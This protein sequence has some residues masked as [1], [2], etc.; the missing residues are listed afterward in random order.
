MAIS[1]GVFND[2]TPTSYKATIDET[3]VIITGLKEGIAD[4]LPTE[5]DGTVI[6]LS[7]AVLPEANNSASISITGGDYTLALDSG[8]TKYGATPGAA[9][10]SYENETDWAKATVSRTMSAGWDEGDGS[11]ITYKDDPQELASITGLKKDATSGI[12]LEANS[13]IEVGAA[14][15]GTNTVTLTNKVTSVFNYTLKLADGIADSKSAADN[16]YEVVI[17]SGTLTA[18]AQHNEYWTC[19]GT[20]ITHA[21][22]GKDSSAAATVSN[23][24]NDATATSDAPNVL[25]DAGTNTFTLKKSALQTDANTTVTLTDPNNKGFSLALY[26]GDDTEKVDIAGTQAGTNFSWGIKG[27]KAN[28]TTEAT[29]DEETATKAATI[30]KVLTAGWTLGKSNEGDTTN[31]KITYSAGRTLTYATISGLAPATTKDTLPDLSSV[32]DEEATNENTAKALTLTKANFPT[33]TTTADITLTNEYTTTEDKVK[34]NFKI[35]IAAGTIDTTAVDLDKYEVKIDDSGDTATM[36]VNQMVAEYCDSTDIANGTKL[37]YH[38]EQANATPL[39]TVTGLAKTATFAL[40]TDTAAN[41]EAAAIIVNTASAKEITLK[42]AAFPTSVVAENTVNLTSTDGY[43]LKLSGVTAPGTDSDVVV[44]ED[45]QGT[46][47]KVQQTKT[48]G[49]QLGEAITSEGTKT[50]AVTYLEPEATDLATITVDNSAMG[51]TKDAFTVSGTTVKVANAALYSSNEGNAT[52]ISIDNTEGQT[53]ALALA[54]DVINTFGK[55]NINNPYIGVYDD[56]PEGSRGNKIAEVRQNVSD[57]WQ[58]ATADDVAATE[59]TNIGEIFYK[60]DGY[61][62]LATVTGLTDAADDNTVVLNGTTITLSKDALPDEDAGFDVTSLENNPGQ[63]Y[64]LA[65][66]ETTFNTEDGVTDELKPGTKYDPDTLAIVASDSEQGDGDGGEGG[67]NGN[68]DG[69]TETTVTPV[70]KQITGTLNAGWKL[71]SDSSQVKYFK[72]QENIVLATIKNVG[73][74]LDEN[75][76]GDEEGTEEGTT[77]DTNVLYLT[78]IYLADKSVTL[79]NKTVET[80]DGDTIVGT[81]KGD[82]KLALKDEDNEVKPELGYKENYAWTLNSN[83]T[84]AYFKQGNEKGWSIASDS[85]SVT[86]DPRVNPIADSKAKTLLTVTGLKG[87]DLDTNNN[88]LNT[89]NPDNFLD[90]TASAIGSTIG[91]NFVAGLQIDT[92]YTPAVTADEDN[93]IDAVDAVNG[94]ILLKRNVLGT[95]TLEL[96]GTDKDKYDLKLFGIKKTGAGNEATLEFDDDGNAN[97]FVPSEPFNKY[98]WYVNGTNAFYRKATAEYWALNGKKVTYNQQT[99]GTTLAKITGLASGLKV[100]D[101]DDFTAISTATDLDDNFA[102]KGGFVYSGTTTTDAATALSTKVIEIADEADYVAADTEN[103]SE[104]RI[105]TITISQGALT[106]TNVALTDGKDNYDLKLDDDFNELKTDNYKWEVTGSSTKT[107]KYYGVYATAGYNVTDKADPENKF[108]KSITY[109]AVGDKLLATIT[110]LNKDVTKTNIDNDIYLGEK[111]ITTGEGDDE[112]AVTYP[113]FVLNSNVLGTSDVSLTNNAKTADF[114]LALSSSDE[115]IIDSTTKA[116]EEAIESTEHDVW[117]LSGTTAYFRNITPTYYTPQADAMSIKATAEKKNGND[118]VTVTNLASDLVEQDGE[119]GTMVSGTFTKVIDV[120]KTKEDDLKIVVSKGALNESKALTLTDGQKK[121]TFEFATD[122]NDAPDA[123]E[124]SKEIGKAPKWTVANNTATLKGTF[125]AGWIIDASTT[126]KSKRMVHYNELTGKT[127]ATIKGLPSN[128]SDS[129]FVN[130]ALPTASDG[131][132]VLPAKVF[133]GNINDVT[134]TNGKGSDNNDFKY[135]IAIDTTGVSTAGAAIEGDDRWYLEGTTLSLSKI[136]D[137]HHEDVAVKTDKGTSTDGVSKTTIKYV[138]EVVDTPDVTI[139]NLK[140]DLSLNNSAVTNIVEGDKHTYYKA[141]GNEPITG[142]TVNGKTITLTSAVVS[143]DPANVTTLANKEGAIS[144]QEYKLA[145]DVATITAPGDG[146]SFGIEGTKATLYSGKTAGYEWTSKTIAYKLPT[147]DDPIATITGLKSGLVV[148]GATGTAMD[149]IGTRDADGDFTALVTYPGSGNN[150][151]FTIKQDALTNTDVTVDNGTLVLD[152]EVTAAWTTNKTAYAWKVSGTE[153]TYNRGNKEGWEI[154]TADNSKKITYHKEDYPTVVATV[155]NLASGLQVA[156][157]G[158][159]V[160][161]K[162]KKTAISLGSEGSKDKITL[163]KFALNAKDVLLKIATKDDGSGNVDDSKKFSL[164]LDNTMADAST[165]ADTYVEGKVVTSVWTQDATDKG[166]YIYTVT[167][168]QGYDTITDP[169]ETDLTVNKVVY[170]DRIVYTKDSKNITTL[171]GLATNLSISSDKKTLGSSGQVTVDDTNLKVSVKKAALGGNNV[172]LK[173][174]SIK[175]TLDISDGADPVENVWTISKGTAS[176]IKPYKEKSYLKKSDTE[177]T[178][179]GDTAGK[180]VVLATITG[181]DTNISE[182]KI[183]QTKATTDYG[184]SVTDGADVTT[185]T[186]DDRSKLAAKNIVLKASKDAGDTKYV[187][188]INAANFNTVTYTEDAPLWAFSKGTLTLSTGTS[189]KWDYKSATDH[190]TLTYTKGSTTPAATVKGLATDLTLT[191]NKDGTVDANK[192]LMTAVVKNDSGTVTKNATLALSVDSSGDTNLIKLKEGALVASPKNNAKITLT[193]PKNSTAF[194]LDV[195]GVTK[196]TAAEMDKTNEAVLA[197]QEENKWSISKGTATYQYK[198]SAGWQLDADAKNFTYVNTAKITPLAKISGL[199]TDLTTFNGEKDAKG[200][201]TDVPITQAVFQNDTGIYLEPGTTDEGESITKFTLKDGTKL[202]GKNVTLAVTDKTTNYGI[203]AAADLAP[204]DFDEKV[205]V[206]GTKGTVTLTA[207]TSDGYTNATGKNEGKS[208]TYSKEKTANILFSVTGLKKDTTSTAESAKLATLI[209]VK[210]DGS[211]NESKSALTYNSEEK[212]VSIT[213]T[214]ILD[215]TAS[216]SGKGG[217]TF[218]AFDSS[219]KGVADVNNT[220]TLQIKS[221]TINVVET[222]DKDRYSVSADGKKITFNTKDVYTILATVKGLDKNVMTDAATGTKILTSTTVNKVQTPGA[223]VGTFDAINGTITL[224]DKALA[225]GNIT[226]TLGKNVEEGK[227]SVALGSDVMTE[228]GQWE[229]ITEWTSSNGTATYKTYNKGYY[230]DDGKGGFKYNKETKGT[231]YATITGLNKDADD[232][233]A[234]A[235]NSNTTADYVGEILITKDM[236][237]EKN[238]VLK[239]T[240]DKD[241]NEGAFTIALDTTSGNKVADADISNF[242]AEKTFVSGKLT[243]TQSKGYLKASDTQI[244]YLKDAKSNQLVATLSGIDT[245]A[246]G[247][248]VDNNGV[249]ELGTGTKGLNGKNVTLTTTDLA[250]VDYK[251]RLASGTAESK[252]TA[253][254]DAWTVKNGTA[255]YKGFITEGYALAASGKSITYTKANGSAETTVNGKTKA[256]V[257]KDL[258]T[259]KGVTESNKPTENAAVSGTALSSTNAVEIKDATVTISTGLFP[260]NFKGTSITGSKEADTITIASGKA[261]TV[262]PG[263]GDDKIT[264][265]SGNYKDTFVYSN[266]DG[267]DVVANFTADDTIKLKSGKLTSVEISGSDAVV[268]V[269]TGS[270][271]LT[272]KSTTAINIVDNKGTSLWSAAPTGAS[273]VLLADNNYSQDAAALSDIVEPFHASYTPYDFESGLDLVKKDSFAPAFTYTGDSDKK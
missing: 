109:T 81:A 50:Q 92:K 237:A 163:T 209:V 152:S 194:A 205:T 151:A 12:T 270:I 253:A 30:Q 39:A 106:T 61:N 26:S 252:V 86:F 74:D 192:G 265:D 195:D 47:Y 257:Y 217:Y 133:I 162:N 118:Y 154:L 79:T 18:T 143:T 4:R 218:A 132:F 153:A 5:I 117:R 206:D 246:T 251:L 189:G 119:I 94:T 11:T 100:M 177:Y 174:G 267:N 241:G 145:P 211:I 228:S 273:D 85:L 272:G 66:D 15:L 113:A 242:T 180:D 14:A 183:A 187:F 84:T 247:I 170:D 225:N 131:N 168:T 176:Y 40:S 3:E 59:A 1:W 127:I 28:G 93:N 203:Y 258:M 254:T 158:Q 19:N 91:E 80:K 216:I 70:T 245:Q 72:A 160:I 179:T 232:K 227:F 164:A 184:I 141:T 262:E 157:D 147:Q 88:T 148:G 223:E 35:Q 120:D 171:T 57:G 104:E 213:D 146:E 169:S 230:S 41:K 121:Y 89:E 67:E 239:N 58:I 29:N 264:L 21:N 210:D 229:D 23:L 46:T 140:K 244:T 159:S 51:I 139:T 155:S 65:L 191:T 261:V 56:D 234:T 193:L 172:V 188:D 96:A 220:L 69:A 68:A 268:K 99:T 129:D 83:K 134:L 6:T 249:I 78:E 135:G 215:K 226:F 136:H 204:E 224:Q 256:A 8:V 32:T 82:F 53:Y 214:A 260:V 142:V 34:S 236:I 73:E 212:T 95:G 107:A 122:E 185:I 123:V 36:T 48:K 108:G 222:A 248:T 103:E 64:K 231:T 115:K 196:A 44:T 173:N 197:Y 202:A 49:W 52:S 137:A 208:V 31:N 54:D 62:V 98:V 266:G 71:A 201:L 43:N 37:T 138:K 156:E 235:F 112:N 150:R 105:G 110:G 200:N 2:Q 55:E 7:E 167:T 186:L 116:G 250:T 60:T 233:I 144:S 75:I 255:S 126:G 271:T 13:K 17:S 42:E 161:D 182:T 101:G 238:I 130:V 181:F 190:N 207:G 219:T 259:V 87:G 199:A 149:Q 263:K 269:G 25:F 198:T 124:I 102:I 97:T 221:G 27:Y 165:K 128:V 24:A 38:A 45:T 10:V 22:A 33:T 175:Y 240:K 114:R 111:S 63:S 76:F 90:P 77:K 16:G 178:Y 166:K 243:G 20:T 125:T 9:T